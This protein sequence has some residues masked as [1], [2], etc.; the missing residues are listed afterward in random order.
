M[1]SKSGQ[2]YRVKASVQ[3]WK[4]GRYGTWAAA[5][6]HSEAPTTSATFGVKKLGAQ[7]APGETFTCEIAEEGG[8]WRVVAMITD[9]LPSILE[10]FVAIVDEQSGSGRA[11]GCSLM[12]LDPSITS[13]LRPWLPQSVLDDAHIARL[14]VNSK[15]VVSAKKVTS[16]YEV[17]V[18]HSP[19]AGIAFPDWQSSDA[20]PSQ[21][22][23]AV[24][25]QDWSRDRSSKA[26]LFAARAPDAP[27]YARIWI[28]A[29]ALRAVGIRALHR[30]TLPE[31]ESEV[32]SAKR[33][34]QWTEVLRTGTREAINALRIDRVSVLIESAKE[35]KAW[36]FHHLL[37]PRALREPHKDGEVVDWVYG[38]VLSIKE[39]D[40]EEGNRIITITFED[41]RL[42]RGEGRA[43]L[44]T[45]VVTGT[46]LDP[47][48]PV[49][50]RLI[51]RRPYWNISHVHRATPALR[52][53]DDDSQP[54]Q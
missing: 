43:F 45:S 4:S 30:A 38:R 35:G 12:P 6:I 53:I 13:G 26:V 1:T 24:A 39:K 17:D 34:E 23:I 11:K 28:D 42:G 21:P 46:G 33:I 37:A 10:P 25:L 22:V 15:V 20:S 2:R 18:L 36:K 51:S 32:E 7:P 9:D 31:T 14:V 40:G 8:R 5:Q 29:K 27:V 49:V 50:I 19:H 47:S 54:T 48:V 16:G 3:E 52:A 41:K 44:A